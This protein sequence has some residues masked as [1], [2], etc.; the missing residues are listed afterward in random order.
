MKILISKS[1]FLT[2][3]ILLFSYLIVSSCSTTY[4]LNLNDKIA[5]K[6]NYDFIFDKAYEESVIVNI[7][8]SEEFGNQEVFWSLDVGNSIYVQ[9]RATLLS[10]GEKCYVYFANETISTIGESTAISRSNYYRDEF[11]DLIYEKNVELM[12]SPDGRIG[13][14]DGDPKVTIFVVPLNGAGGLYLQKDEVTGLYSNCREMIYIDSSLGATK[15]A[16]M[17]IMHEFNHL[18][19]FNNEM[20]E[21]HF[22][23]EGVAEFAVYFGGYLS[24][25]TNN[26]GINLT[27]HTNNFKINHQKS[28][29]SFY[30]D[31]NSPFSEDYGQSYMFMFYLVEQFG[32]DFLKELVLTLLDGPKGIDYALKATDNNITFN[33]VYLNWIT[34]C[35]IDQETIADGVY[36]F[37]NADFVVDP[38]NIISN[39]PTQESN[40][41]HYPYGCHVMKLLNPPDNFKLTVTNPNPTYSLGVSIAFIDQ[42]GW[43]VHQ[44]VY[45]DENELINIGLTGWNI[46]E[47][48]I[49]TSLISQKTPDTFID[50]IEIENEQSFL[51][52]FSILEGLVDE[53]TNSSNLS[54]FISTSI[55]V[56][57]ITIIQIKKKK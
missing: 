34:A 20:D 47:A 4:I 39:Y 56:T 28:L 27:W 36:S 18:I 44:S 52:D 3:I 6:I 9:K 1:I 42:K 55:L 29:L 43:H 48:Y 45:S 14:I 54:S 24:S 35:A 15:G 51:L 16:L 53:T 19:W 17:T 46:E 10:I 26:P 8:A 40:I 25:P 38:N 32:I 2:I 37:R 7:N 5:E 33:E 30:L 11:D 22:L 21:G 23:L 12:G 50:F 31:N 49:C 13:D 57:I 41:K